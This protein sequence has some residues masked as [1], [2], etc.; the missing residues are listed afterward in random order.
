MQAHIE[1]RGW[2]A[3]QTIVKQLIDNGYE[4][5]VGSDGQ[6]HDDGSLTYTVDFVHPDWSGQYFELVDDEVPLN[7]L[8]GTRTWED[9]K[10]ETELV[11]ADED[12]AFIDKERDRKLDEVWAKKPAKKKSKKTK[13]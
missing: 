7:H 12:L 8:E 10:K 5:L 4:V 13:K 11:V 6:V 9:I 3:V 1:V 2:E